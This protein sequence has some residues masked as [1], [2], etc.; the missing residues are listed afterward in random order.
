MTTGSSPLATSA[1]TFFK[2]DCAR[3]R[4]GDWRWVINATSDGVSFAVSPPYPC[5]L[6][7]QVYA[8]THGREASHLY[9]W[10]A[11]Q[12]LRGLTRLL[13]PRYGHPWR[14]PF[15]TETSEQDLQRSIIRQDRKKRALGQKSGGTC[16]PWVI[17]HLANGGALHIMDMFTS[18]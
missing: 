7:R 16:S 18:R 6:R 4:C 5:R 14:S 10:G 13:L 8:P 17:F 15:Q 1:G 11:S 2:V 9:E 3:S 12:F